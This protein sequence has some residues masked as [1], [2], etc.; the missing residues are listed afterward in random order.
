MKRVTLVVDVADEQ[1]LKDLYITLTERTYVHGVRLLNFTNGNMISKL[2]SY[3]HALEL[4]ERATELADCKKIAEKTLDEGAKY[5][6]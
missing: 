1:F 5:D 4:I 6:R 2:D 3:E